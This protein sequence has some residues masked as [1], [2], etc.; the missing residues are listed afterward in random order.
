M[1]MSSCSL[2]HEN[3]SNTSGESGVG[4]SGFGVLRIGAT[5][6]EPLL[7]VNSVNTVDGIPT[8]ESSGKHFVNT[9]DGMCDAN[10]G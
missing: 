9:V 1:R 5:G 8:V 4:N 7:E 10:C 3:Q 2:L 6:D